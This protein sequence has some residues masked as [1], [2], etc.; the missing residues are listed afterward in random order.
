[1]AEQLDASKGEF[2]S[3][4]KTSGLHLAHELAHA[5]QRELLRHLGKSWFVGAECDDLGFLCSE[6]Q[7]V[8][9]VGVVSSLNP[10]HLDLLILEVTHQP[11]QVSNLVLLVATLGKE[12]HNAKA[13]G[14]AEAVYIWRHHML[15]HLMVL[16]HYLGNLLSWRWHRCWSRWCS[17]QSCIYEL[18]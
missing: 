12:G 3:L 7:H 14:F 17:Q 2:I 6:V 11:A 15:L 4:R 9:A 5:V 1:M 16:V 18:S 8:L 10:E 13:I